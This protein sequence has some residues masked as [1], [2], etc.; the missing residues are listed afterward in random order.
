MLSPWGHNSWWRLRTRCTDTSD[1]G[2]FGPKTLRTYRSSDPG[3]FGMTEVSRHFG[4]RPKCLTDTL[5]LD[6]RLLTSK[7]NRIAH[8]AKAYP[9]IADNNFKFNS[10]GLYRA[11]LSLGG[12]L[13]SLVLTMS[14]CSAPCSTASGWAEIIRRTWLQTLQTNS[15]TE[16]D[17]GSTRLSVVQEKLSADRTSTLTTIIAFEL[18]SSATNTQN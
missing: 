2:P 6:S 5:A 3:H 14:S 12:E 8:Y 18:S 9:W 15:R 16:G 17:S 11:A 13:Q 4:T 7:S 1:P 10:S